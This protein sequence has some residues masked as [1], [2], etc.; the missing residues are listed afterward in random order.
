MSSEDRAAWDVLV[1]GAGPSGLATAAALHAYGASVLVVDEQLGRVRESR[2]LAVQPRTLEL[3]N[4]FGLAD[5]LVR[6]GNPA[7]RLHLHLGRREVRTDLFG[8]G[9]EDSAYPFLLFVSQAET[10]A[11]LGDHLAGEGVAVER[12][13]AAERISET[14]TGCEVTI[15]DDDGALRDVRARYVV[16][17]DGAYSTVR[18]EAGIPFVGGGY[19]QTFVLADLDVDG[20]E[21]GAVHSFLTDSGPFFFF[22]LVRPAGW[23]VIAVRSASPDAST[24]PVGTDELQRLADDATGGS[25][26][27]HE[28]VWA[29]AFRIQHR[30][31]AT[32][33]AG[34]LFVAGDAAHIH[35][36]A[37]AQGMNTGIQD[38]INVGWKLALVCRGR[39]PDSLLDTYDLERRPVGAMVLRFTDRAFNAATSARPAVR[40]VRRRVA[41]LVVPF[42]L[43]L[44]PVRALGFRRVSQL[45]IAYRC[46]QAV[47]RRRSRLARG[48]Y[49]GDRLPDAAISIDGR[50]GRLHDALRR[51]GF[52]LLLVGE[53]ETWDR[54]VSDTLV[55]EHP[56]MLSV[57]LL[58]REPGPG[59]L[60]DATGVA[61]RRLRVRGAAVFV[62]RPDGHI[63]HRIDE[64]DLDGARR[65][66][67]GVLS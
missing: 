14:S 36:P 61:F 41:P 54:G 20:L 27:L 11:L 32:Y 2:A 29:T 40:F 26:R 43:G 1:V 39:A 5:E 65:Y 57:Q 50:P 45:D 44:R 18:A 56:G 23:R 37:G 17:C 34:R 6:R 16:G 19:P 66:L 60:H 58:S 48:P 59:V 30:H 46:G 53:P 7:V 24:G 47:D 51:K 49:A 13:V 12:G 4:G 8:V 62:V 55:T 10:E 22:P 63:G 67:S 35:S 52:Q 15:R 21:P 42:V 9:L 38:G 28:P 31:A 25:V 33:R 3:L 64:P